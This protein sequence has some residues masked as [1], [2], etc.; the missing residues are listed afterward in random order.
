MNKPPKEANITP[1]RL[2]IAIVSLSLVFL[3]SYLKWDFPFAVPIAAVSIFLSVAL[4]Q[5]KL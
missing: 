1:F 5:R 2:T 4:T 3:N